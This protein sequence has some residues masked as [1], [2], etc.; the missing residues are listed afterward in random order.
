M[1]ANFYTIRGG[2]ADDYDWVIDHVNAWWGGRSMVAM[3]PRLFFLHFAPW[4]FIAERDAVIIGFLAGFRSQTDARHAY[5]HFVGISPEA[6]GLGV[7]AALYNRLCADAAAAG[8]TEVFSITSPSNA[9][10]IA[11]HR[12][13]GFTL[14]PGPAIAKDIPYVPNYDG[15]GEDR[16]RFV[17]RL[18]K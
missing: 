14:M 10:S 16:V 4:T 3:L 15:P 18:D 8:C 1:E 5:C 2:N 12:R 9:S 13:V 6:R 11:F 17:M 7:G